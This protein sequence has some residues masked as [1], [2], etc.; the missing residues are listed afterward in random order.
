M[1]NRGKVQSAKCHCEEERSSDAAI[2]K[3]NPSTFRLFDLS[4]LTSLLTSKSCFKL[5]CGAGNE[6]L[7]EVEKLV[8]LYSAAGCK[9]FDLSANEEVLKAAQ[10]GLDFSI[11]K[12]EQKD[13]HFCVS[14]G[15]KNDAH[16]NK[17]RIDS[18]KCTG[19]GK[20]VEVCPQKAILDAKMQRC[21]DAKSRFE[22][23][24]KNCIGCS[25]CQKV[26]QSD[27]IYFTPHPVFW[28]SQASAQ[29]ENSPLPQGARELQ[30]T[31]HH[32]PFTC[33][34]LHVSDADSALE[35]WE[36]LCSQDYEML[37]ICIGRKVFSNEKIAELLKKMVA[38]RPPYTTMI[39]ADGNP[40][41]GGEDDFETTLPAVKTGLFI[42]SLNLPV[43]VILSGGTNSKTAQLCKEKGLEVNGIAFGSYARKIVRKY[44]DRKDF[45]TNK[46][47]FEEASKIAKNL[48]E[49][50]F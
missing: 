16:F 40:M 24:E 37:S 22:V 47:I 15:T 10:K 31:I 28:F 49:S 18:K 11:P 20:C 46:A 12:D 9:F 19:C 13:Y 17:A 14:I 39:Q 41:S 27:A 5:I 44:I 7:D 23:I 8:A 32:S 50:A 43:Y 36:D 33:L 3:E 30:F 6:N 38:K 2:Q 29:T 48:V 45:W 25:K 1:V 21:K 42:K 35:Q 4:T 34:E 26:C